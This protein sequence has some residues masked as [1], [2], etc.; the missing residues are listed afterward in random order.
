[1]Y[2][3]YLK[4]YIILQNNLKY[5]NTFHQFDKNSIISFFS[6]NTMRILKQFKKASKKITSFKKIL[7][8]TLFSNNIH[9]AHVLLFYRLI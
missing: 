3:C 1:M 2:D 5:D 9:I 6:Y 8:H 4:T 7:F